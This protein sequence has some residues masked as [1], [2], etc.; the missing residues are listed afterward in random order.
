MFKGFAVLTTMLIVA[1]CEDGG[2]SAEALRESDA[3]NYHLMDF[4]QREV[5]K[6]DSYTYNPNLADGARAY[7]DCRDSENC[8]VV[9]PKMVRVSGIYR[10]N[11]SPQTVIGSVIEYW[12]NS[13]E[14]S[15]NEESLQNK[16]A[17]V[18]C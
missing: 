12:R 18:S 13:Q 16:K 6:S 2:S 11:G 5:G 10:V 17:E 15:H 1:R 3:K 8:L 7:L 9:P 4:L 14:S